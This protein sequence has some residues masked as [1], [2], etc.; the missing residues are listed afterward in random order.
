MR[1]GATALSNHTPDTL[2]ARPA[3]IIS[4]GQTG[5][6]MGGLLAARDLGI[7]TG[8]VAPKGYRTERGPQPL[9]KDLG[10]TESP[11]A[12]YQGRTADNVEAA[13]GTV[14]FG[15][16]RSP[17]SALTAKL[18]KQA[19]KPWIENPTV[20]ELRTFIINEQVQVLNVAGNRES[21]NPGIQAGV[22]EI[23]VEAFS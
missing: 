5:A 10:L 17:G 16:L 8:G 2:A 6:D 9:L 3:K 22:R 12:S 11:Y 21:K 19:G 20:Q 13:D 4:G 7:P 14:L 18:C 23:L 1:L 15:N